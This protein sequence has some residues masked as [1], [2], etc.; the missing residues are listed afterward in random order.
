MELLVVLF[1]V[2]IFSGIIAKVPFF[3]RVSGLSVRWLLFFFVLKVISGA[4]LVFIYTYYYTE[5]EF[6][7][8]YKYFNDGRV[9]FSALPNSVPDYLRMVT[10]ID[11]ATPHLDR[12]YSQMGHWV[13]PWESVLYNDNRLVIRFNAL[14]SLFSMGYIQVHSVFINFLSFSGLIALLGF[15]RRYG[16]AEK[17]QW[18]AP[19][20]FLFP[21]LLFW[22]SGVLKEGLLIWAF[23]FWNFYLDGLRYATRKQWPKLI[24]LLLAYTWLLI[25]LKP[26]TFYL[27]LPCLTGFYLWK[28]S[29]AVYFNLRLILLLAGIAIVTLLLGQIFPKYNILTI[30]AAK[31][32]DFIAQSI[33]YDAG[34]LIQTDL[35]KPTLWDFAKAFPSGLWHSLTRP[36]L[37]EA[38]S[39]VTLMAALEN[40]FIAAII[41]YS[42]LSAK[43]GYAN[44]IN[45][46][47]SALWFVILL[48]GLIGMVTV[49][50]GG[51]VRYRIPALPFLWFIIIHTAYLPRL[52]LPFIST[53]NNKF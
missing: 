35:L 53:R 11:A 2:L 16:H 50:H 20:I 6:A 51:M 10:G 9:I 39:P 5:T 13:R 15:F 4:I 27:W 40:F 23:G 37:F 21:G 36:H 44:H 41:L 29:G 33:Y 8:I 34:S 46:K 43:K 1:Y 42:L 47:W 48:L 3:S 22:G 26:Y 24:F 7:D 30:I 19:G 17:I 12:Y 14:V 31:Q 45:L 32:N 38:Y 25:L 28:N 52:R 49:A 18:L